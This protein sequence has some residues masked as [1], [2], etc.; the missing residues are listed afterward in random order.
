MA[1]A[2]STTLE[3]IY[4]LAITGRVDKGRQKGEA[5]DIRI[6]LATAQYR[7][8]V[9]RRVASISR[10]GTNRAVLAYLLAS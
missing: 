10:W 8:R 7:I 3:H 2:Q 5:R 9:S 4:E 1:H 6:D